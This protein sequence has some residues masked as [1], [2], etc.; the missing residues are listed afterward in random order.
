MFPSLCR[1]NLRSSEVQRGQIHPKQIFS[2]EYR[3]DLWDCLVKP[4]LIKIGYSW[5]NMCDIDVKHGIHHL[6]SV[7]QPEGLKCPT[8]GLFTSRTLN[9]YVVLL[10]T[11]NEKKHF[12]SYREP[13][14]DIKDTL[15]A[16]EDPFQGS[17]HPPAWQGPAES[18]FGE[19]D[20]FSLFGKG[21][22]RPGTHS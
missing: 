14:F 7:P 16:S 20:Q 5:R 6:R 11:F 21:P 4:K 12:A 10:P 9:C 13:G 18:K 22:T 8:R 19:N 15:Q 1:S 17:I 3:Q 2:P